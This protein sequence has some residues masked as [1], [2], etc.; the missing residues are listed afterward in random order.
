MPFCSQPRRI[1]CIAR[2]RLDR[3]AVTLMIRFVW[4]VVWLVVWLFVWLFV[5]VFV[6]VVFFD[7]R[8]GDGPRGVDTVD[9]TQL[10][11]NSRWQKNLLQWLS[12]HFPL[13][14][15]KDV[16]GSTSM[17]LFGCCL[18]PSRSA[19]SCTLC[20][21]V[22]HRTRSL[23]TLSAH[24]FPQCAHHYGFCQWRTLA[25]PLPRGAGPLFVRAQLSSACSAIQHRHAVT[26]AGPSLLVGLST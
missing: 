23:A 16:G 25:A 9:T 2:T 6:F 7:R 4:F 13:L 17:E 20:Y 15:E 14:P 19:L 26:S 3:H 18:L 24:C 1:S 10:T 5:F 8:R 12:S 11:G 21:D 22:R